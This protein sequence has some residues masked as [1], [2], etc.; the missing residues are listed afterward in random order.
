[1]G[2][3]GVRAGGSRGAEG[4]QDGGSGQGSQGLE[5]LWDLVLTCSGVRL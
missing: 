5:S 4:V 3:D 1:M 2:L